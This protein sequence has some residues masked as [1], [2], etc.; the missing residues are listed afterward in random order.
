MLVPAWRLP[1]LLVVA[2]LIS[3]ALL[4]GVSPTVLFSSVMVIWL[5]AAG[6]FVVLRRRE[7]S[8]FTP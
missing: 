5:V 7:R 8:M 1:A 6:L 3:V 4:P 2:S